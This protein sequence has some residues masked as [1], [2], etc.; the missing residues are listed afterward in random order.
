MQPALFATQV[1]LAALWR[2]Y[3]VQP[4]AV[5]GHSMGEVAAAH[6]AGALSLADAALVICRRS[7]LLRRVSGRGA[8]LAVELSMAEAAASIKGRADR[9]SV[10]VS[11]G[12]R[13]T[14]LSGDPAALQE[15]ATSLERDE[16][17]CRWVKVDVASHSPQVDE[18]R[19]EL[20]RQLAE[21]RPRPLSVPSAPP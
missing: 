2:S 11:N 8:M 15:I 18:L 17:F 6:V 14:V 19:P 7:R 21:I 13:A 3:G 1:A 16:V 12:A 5:V 4:S 10:A 9:V 20:L